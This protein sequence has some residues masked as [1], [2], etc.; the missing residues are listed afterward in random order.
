MDFPVH[1]STE[2]TPRDRGHGLGAAQS[3]R[4]GSVVEI[5]GRL[6]QHTAQLGPDEMRRRLSTG[7]KTGE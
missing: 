1:H 2:P 3:E 5:Y 6:F 7:E 4:I